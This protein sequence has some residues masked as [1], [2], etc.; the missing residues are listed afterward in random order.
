MSQGEGSKRDYR[1]MARR[2]PLNPRPGSAMKVRGR[3]PGLPGFLAVSLG[4]GQKDSGRGKGYQYA[5]LANST[6]GTVCMR[7]LI[8]SQRDQF[9]M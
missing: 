2:K 4:R 1:E 7:I 6:R 5:P 8:S 3:L 9:S